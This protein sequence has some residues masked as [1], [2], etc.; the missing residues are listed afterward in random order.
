MITSDI[1]LAI[2]SLKKGNV[3]AIPTETVYG[4][5]G[6][7]FEESSVN[8]IF[9]I[10]NRPS[11]NPLIVHIPNPKYINKI[12]QNIPKIAQKL[13]K[14]FWPGPLTLVLEKQRHISDTVT[15]GKSTVA[16]RVPNHKLT[17]DLLSKLPFPLVA[18]S[19]NPFGFT[20]PTSTDHV[21]EYFADKID[22]I[23]DG[24]LSLKG[25]E[26]TIIGF[27]NNN[28]VLYRH[29]SIPIEKIEKIIGKVEIKNKNNLSPE[30]PGMLKRHYA[31]KTKIVFSNDFIKSIKSYPNKKI[32]ILCLKRIEKIPKSVHQEVLSSDGNLN[33]AAKNLYAALH[34]LDRL[35]LDL[36]LT[37]NVPEYE[38]GRSINDRLRRAVEVEN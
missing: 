6:N 36:I 38:L 18:P 21:I 32:G 37:S 28:A 4:L 5:A 24:G 1:N 13:S 7:A 19:A 22:L 27:E 2:E 16:V 23:L 12:A 17:L 33:E 31:P 15:A 10:K 26:S 14:H 35:N 20:S 9:K 30:A 8:K 29:G 34:K 25:I 11:F 3:I